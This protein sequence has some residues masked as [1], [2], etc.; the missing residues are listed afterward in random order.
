[1]IM[2]QWRVVLDFQ[3][4]E[5]S[6]QGRVRNIRTGRFIK[7]VRGGGRDPRNAV[8]LYRLGK[9]YKIH[10]SRLVL[11]AFV[12]P[13]KPGELA[14][15]DD[16]DLSRDVLDHLYWGTHHDNVGDAVRN[17]RYKAHEITETHREI[18]GSRYRGKSLPAGVGQKISAAKLGKPLSTEHRDAIA[19]GQLGRPLSDAHRLA[20]SAGQKARHARRRSRVPT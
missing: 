19:A 16:D 8:G 3:D 10:V 6:S 17:S 2:E 9:Q 13:P 7:P 15:H 18:I 11:T 5:V 4:Y 1:M 12:R 14:L 20:I